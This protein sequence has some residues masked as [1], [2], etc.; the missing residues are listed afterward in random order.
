MRPSRSVRLIVI[1]ALVVPLALSTVVLSGTAWAAKV[2]AKPV[3][4]RTLM[5]TAGGSWG[6]EGC[7]QPAITGGNTTGISIPFPTS[8]GFYT[9]VITWNPA[10]QAHRGPHAGTTTVSFAVT[11][12]T[13]HHNKCGT[14][15]TEWKLAGTIKSNTVSPQVK[16]KLK[17]FA[18]V[19][20]SSHALSGK[21][22]VKL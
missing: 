16:G 3:N 8:V 14:G 10:G 5:G 17:I 20:I 22:P 15:K 4:C 7:T 19:T 11:Q 21:K 13:G 18:C 9:A 6:F 12:R 1:P 2:K